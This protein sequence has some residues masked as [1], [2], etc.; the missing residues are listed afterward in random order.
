M[1]AIKNWK[2]YTDDGHMRINIPRDLIIFGIIFIFSLIGLKALFHP[3]LFTAHDIWHQVVRLYYYYQ[4]AADGQFPPYWIGQLANNFGYPLFFFSYHLPWIIGL[5]FLSFGINIQDTIKILFILSYLGSGF[6][7]YFFAKSLFKDNLSALLSS[8]LY[9][10]VP[11]HFLIIFVGASMGIAFVFTFL[12]V[13]MLGINK[14]KENSKYGVIISALGLSGII[15]SHIMH[16]VFLFPL[17]VAFL[18]WGY[19]N[20]IK[21]FI[22]TKNIVISLLLGI[23]LS[24]FYLLP[25]V[26]YSRFTEVNDQVGFIELYKKNF[27]NFRQ[28]VYSK[29]G[30]YPIVNTAKEADFSFQLGIAQWISILI[31]VVLVVFK[32][33]NKPNRSLALYLLAG[34]VV[35]IFL[36]LDYSKP[37]WAIVSNMVAVDFPFRLILSAVFIASICAGLVLINFTKKLKLFL[38]TFIILVAIYTNRNHLNVN[39]YTNFPVETY[40]NSESEVTTNT[41]NEYLPKSANYLLLKKPWKE[42]FGENLSFS[43]TK[44]ATNLL[45]FN[46]VTNQETNVSIGQ[47]NFA[48]QNLYLDGK[49]SQFTT[50]DG[51]LLSFNIPKGAH[52]I[53]VKFEETSFLKL[54][55]LLTLI[56]LFILF[57]KLAFNKS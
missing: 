3:G 42:I 40:L 7:M 27:I 48:G 47:F 29:W 30:Y 41:F 34:F 25:A 15:L 26:Y 49:R 23:L 50:S 39:L 57:K 8:I 22:F 53:A 24:S 55:K 44:Q 28:L 46:A 56:G 51:G 5:P 18:L 31:L 4:A 52:H 43:N 45:S 37:V 21:K 33:L 1:L 2:S 54:S 9:L 32:R 14:I 6:T 16:L 19:M 17:L 12:P 11:Y 35:S 36:M 10:W 38:L 20:S 13:L